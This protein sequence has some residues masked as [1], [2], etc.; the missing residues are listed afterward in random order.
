MYR[1]TNN[2]FDGILKG[3]CELLNASEATLF[4]FVPEKPLLK[5][6]ASN[7]ALPAL[8]INTEHLL[9]DGF[10]GRILLQRQAVLIHKILSQ[11]EPRVFLDESIGPLVNH[12][13]LLGLPIPDRAATIGLIVF[14]GENFMELDQSIEDALW[15]ALSSIGQALINQVE[16][17][18]Q[19]DRA[20]LYAAEKAIWK[21]KYDFLFENAVEGIVIADE[22]GQVQAANP[23]FIDQSGFSAEELTEHTL[24]SLEP[25]TDGEDGDRQ[26]FPQF[27]SLPGEGRHT[28]LRKDD[29]TATLRYKRRAIQ[30]DDRNYLFSFE[31]SD[32]GGESSHAHTAGED[33]LPRQHVAEVAHDLTN[34]I[35]MLR[36]QTDLMLSRRDSKTDNLQDLYRLRKAE[37]KALQLTRRLVKQEGCPAARAE[38]TDVNTIITEVADFLQP[39][40]GSDIGLNLEQAPSLPP[41]H[42]DSDDLF[43]GVLNLCLNAVEAMPKGGLITIQTSQFAAKDK[44]SGVQNICIAVKDTGVGIKRQ[45]IE[46]IFQNNFTTKSSSSGHGL[47]LAILHRTI[48]HYGGKIRVQSKK[49][50]GSCFE[51]IVP[52]WSFKATEK[53]AQSFQAASESDAEMPDQAYE[54]AAMS[55]SSAEN[56]LENAEASLMSL[57]CPVGQYTILIVEDEELMRSLAERILK[58]WGFKVLSASNGYQALEIFEADPGIVDLVLLDLS[59]PGIDGE[60]VFLRMREVR[61]DTQVLLTSGYQSEDMPASLL[62]AKQVRF[63]HKPYDVSELLKQVLEV[64]S[65][66]SLTAPKQEKTKP[67]P[68]Y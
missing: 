26:A 58:E 34:L 16:A 32:A 3:L 10:V 63:L 11:T 40:I 2:C 15:L 50:S 4:T 14:S 35:H 37:Q 57:A 7:V 61:P 19:R 66:E 54:R 17:D 31:Q 64:L 36:N 48:H 52:A 51:I 13:D 65:P 20:R 44:K 18:F 24:Q 55:A 21:R 30:I 47:G 68:S 12:P 56:L 41:V 6:V 60:K 46:N 9:P 62:D 1:K 5:P 45:E 23:A 67:R 8:E 43:H 38:L 29:S 25:L 49:N 42:I 39:M 22:R 53:I 59:L 28:I 33:N 27:T